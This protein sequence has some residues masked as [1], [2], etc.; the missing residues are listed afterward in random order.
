MNFAM[1][2]N[3][4]QSVKLDEIVDRVQA[5]R[6][7]EETSYLYRH[8]LPRLPDGT[9]DTRLNIVWR[10]KI[11]QWSYN[12]VDHFDLSREVVAV[13]LS[14]FDRYL[15][16]LGNRCNGNMA[17][18]TSL[19]TLHIAIKLHDPKKIK[20]STLANLS[21][22]QFGPKDIEQMEW[23]ILSALRWKLHPPTHYAFVSHLLLFLPQEA[24]AAVRKGLNELSKYLTEL[25]VCDSYFVDVYS[26]TVAFAAILNVMEDMNYSRLSGGLREKFLSNLTH[27][28]GLRHGAQDVID[29]RQRLRKMIAASSLPDGAA[30][31]APQQAGRVGQ[32]NLVDN[33]SLSSSGSVGSVVSFQTK[34][35]NSYRS[36]TN[37]YD[38]GKGSCRYSPSPR[39]S[40]VASL[41]S[42]M[43]G[44]SRATISSSPMVAGVQ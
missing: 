16:T 39:R 34:S 28:V 41:S 3:N 11:C 18:L 37:S 9:R 24:N 25:A 13:S 14:L 1:K 27:K 21:R 20:L 5:M 44:T 7:Q 15:A 35:A 26:S 31:Y 36:R 33:A 2:R 38:S 19:T 32:E 30:A 6:K 10:E 22:G 4:Q 42:P 43:V 8:F 29:A 23:T 12:V 40:F 17:L